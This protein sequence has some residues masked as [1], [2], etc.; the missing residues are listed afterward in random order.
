MSS[1]IGVF[2]GSASSF[3]I[4]RAAENIGRAL[5]EE[6]SVHLIS[7][8]EALAKDVSH[9]YH[10]YYGIFRNE[11]ILGEIAALRSYIKSGKPDALLQIT[12]PP[13]HGTVVGGLA[14][15][16]DIPFVYRYSG[17]RFYEHNISQRYNKIIHFG[18]NNLVGR[19]PLPLADSCIALGPTGKD[20]LVRRGVNKE[21]VR[22]I[23]PIID[24]TRFSPTGP[25][26]EFDT[27]RY[28]GLFVGRLSR[29]KGKST[30]ERVLPEI[31]DRRSDLQFVFI[32][33]Q[34][35]SLNIPLCCK[36]NVTL[37]GPVSPAAVAKYYR[38]SSF[39]I[40]PSL[41]EGIPRT[42]LEA[43]AA[44]VP[45]IARDVGDIDYV[46]SNTFTTEPKFVNLVCNFESLQHDSVTRFTHNYLKSEYTRLFLDII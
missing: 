10:E 30:I 42:V 29:R 27:D 23:P 34:P 14:A 24:E 45:T 13:I 38:A 5:S 26:I 33:K 2:V 12:Q 9:S 39:V 41:S 15:V 43:N 7:T 36:D 37:I 4:T 25:R 11:S 32:G 1:T 21:D 18:V 19:T 8:Q 17:D 35:E 3:N 22:I 16:Y 46:T 28:I 6:F 40:H 20:R 44:G 31:L